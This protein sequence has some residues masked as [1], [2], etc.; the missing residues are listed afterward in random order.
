LAEL[1]A[2]VQLKMACLALDVP[3]V[4]LPQPGD[5]GFGRA[6]H[7]MDGRAALR[8]L[9]V[10]LAGLG[11]QALD[12]GPGPGEACGALSPDELVDAPAGDADIDPVAQLT[13]R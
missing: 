11:A 9:Q 1:R 4:Q 12:I 7:G 10:V 8:Q 3:A 13:V 5:V 2:Q 6:L